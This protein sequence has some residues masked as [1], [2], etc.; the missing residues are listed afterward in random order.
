MSHGRE[1]GTVACIE[2]IGREKAPEAVL[3]ARES[4]VEDD[5][6]KTVKEHFHM[7]YSVAWHIIGNADDAKDIA[8]ETFLKLH[9]KYRKYSRNRVL[10]PWL[11][12][13]AVNTAIDHLRRRQ[14]RR[15][16]SLD[17]ELHGPVFSQSQIRTI[18]NME[19]HRII[20]SAADA[21]SPKQKAAFILRDIEGMP[22]N[23]IAGVLK[24]SRSAARSHLSHA[25]SRL[26]EIIAR[27]YP[28]L[29]TGANNRSEQ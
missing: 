13:I 4:L 24:C 2:L 15:E 18:H 17:P 27:N 29:L 1:T 7:V 5:F 21:L 14:R 16:T 6:S 19:I 9:R 25:R 28:E 22:F 26:R 12:R 23:D 10:R 8:Q 11:Y 20:M 3:G